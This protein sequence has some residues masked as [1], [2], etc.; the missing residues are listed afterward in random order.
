MLEAD[1][2]EGGDAGEFPEH[3]HRHQIVSQHQAEHGQHE[4]QQVGVKAAEVDMAGQITAGIEHDQAADATDQQG[5]YQREAVQTQAQVDAQCRNPADALHHR[6]AVGDQRY[7]L[8]EPDKSRQ[9]CQHQQPTCAST[10]QARQAGCHD[11]SQGDQ[12][13]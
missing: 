5:K 11:G 2:Q 3:E 7:L 6:A 13:Q 10:Q 1:Q 8:N 4:H 12:G 9:R